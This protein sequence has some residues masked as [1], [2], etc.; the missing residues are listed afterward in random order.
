MEKNIKLKIDKVKT[1]RNKIY[2]MQKYSYI[3]N[4]SNMKPKY[5]R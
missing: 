1:F 4:T 5:K 2:L 3:F